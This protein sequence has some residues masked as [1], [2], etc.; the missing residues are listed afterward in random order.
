[1]DA[2]LEGLRG[3]GPAPG[4]AG[5]SAPANLL[6]L[7]APALEMIATAAG[8]CPRDRV[9]LAGSHPILHKSL[10]EFSISDNVVVQGRRVDSLEVFRNVLQAVPSLPIDPPDLQARPLA[11]LAGRIGWMGNLDDET[12]DADETRGPAFDDTLAT[13]ERMPTKHRRLMDVPLMMLAAQVESLQPAAQPGAFQRLL[14]A[15]EPPGSQADVLHLLAGRMEDL[16]EAARQQAF[17]QV[18]PRAVRLEPSLPV[19]VAA[20]LVGPLPKL[21]QAAQWPAF[22]GLLQ[23]CSSLAAEQ[24]AVMLR[25]LTYEIGSLSEPVWLPAVRGVLAAAA[26]LAPAQRWTVL[27]PLGQQVH[28]LPVAEQSS[29]WRAVVRSVLNVPSG[30]LEAALAAMTDQ[31]ATLSD[32]ANPQLRPAV[33]LRPAVLQESQAWL[34]RGEDLPPGPHATMLH[35]LARGLR[36]LPPAERQAIFRLALPSIPRPHQDEHGALLTELAWAIELLPEA[37]R[38]PEWQATLQAVEQ[39]PPSMEGV[40]LLGVLAEQMGKLP[41]DARAAAFESLLQAY[42]TSSEPYRLHSAQVL[43]T[44]CLTLPR[45]QWPHALDRVLDEVARLPEELRQAPLL[46]MAFKFCL[47]E[48]AANG[49]IDPRQPDNPRLDV[50]T[51]CLDRI[52][53]SMPPLPRRPSAVFRQVVDTL[54]SHVQALVAQRPDDAAFLNE[55]FERFRGLAGCPTPPPASR[56]WLARLSRYL[57]R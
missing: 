2:V 5:N 16:P 7:P 52:M 24:R 10:R 43:G 56:G 30:Q 6:G 57:R 44:G 48:P 13:I 34:Q 29:T 23:Q 49:P 1:V 8:M 42:R 45:A 36:V 55:G 14:L 40:A 18:L 11:V 33:P 20:A 22:S 46:M 51:Q 39:L 31:I 25:A 27:K 41:M 50:Q 54:S 4:Q 28:R 12:D 3:L 38:Q 47:A 15:Q 17:T 9:M 26:S 35:M 37:A 53:E 19:G 21:P 32:V